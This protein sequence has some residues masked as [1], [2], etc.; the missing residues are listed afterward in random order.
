[1]RWF[2]AAV[3]YAAVLT[4]L[5][6]DVLFLG[7]TLD[8][9]PFV[10][11]VT[12]VEAGRRGPPL[13]ND[14]GASVWAFEPWN[15]LVHHELFEHGHVPLWNPYQATGAPLVASF[16]S[17]VFSPLQWPLF[18]PTARFWW[19]FLLIARL[20]LAGLFFFLFLRR[21]GLDAGSA[22]LG[23]L[24]YML[25]GYFIDYINMSHLA[26]SLLL[27]AGFYFLEGWCRW[28]RARDFIGIVVVLSLM[29]LAGMPEAIL[30]SWLF[31]GL[32]GAFRL[33]ALG[34]GRPAWTRFVCSFVSAFAVSAILLIPGIGY[35]SLCHSKHLAIVYGMRSFPLETAIGYLVPYVFGPPAS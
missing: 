9:Y 20:L 22:W 31:L 35:L 18:L 4:V 7:R 14:A 32:Y 33:T 16:Q 8:T 23:G 5:F 11:G 30:L 29:V 3:P 12:Y 21:I 24:A 28:F 6:F 15:R 19:D 2:R 34:R 25:T 26:I 17:G 13:C 1:M 27:P 10:P